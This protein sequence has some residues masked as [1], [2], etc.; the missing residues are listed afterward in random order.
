MAKRRLA[1]SIEES[2]GVQFP[3]MMRQSGV[4]HLVRSGKQAVDKTTDWA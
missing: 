1:Y 4:F 2:T 3:A